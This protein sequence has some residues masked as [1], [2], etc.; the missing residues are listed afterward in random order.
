MEPSAGSIELPPPSRPEG[1]PP[2]PEQHPAGTGETLRVEATPEKPSPP[3]STEKPPAPQATPAPLPL[4]DHV[5]DDTSQLTQALP[6]NLI[7]AFASDGN[8]IDPGWVHAARV[9]IAN[10]KDNPF[11]E[12][13]AI[14]DLRQKYRERRSGTSMPGAA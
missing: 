11:L 5:S 7:P 2:S 4:P 13:Q 10:T 9:A 1:S 3:S 8:K 14:A 6:A 12:G